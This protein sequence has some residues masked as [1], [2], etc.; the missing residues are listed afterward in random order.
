MW[1]VFTLVLIVYLLY[2]YVFNPAKVVKAPQEPDLF[3]EHEEVI[4]E[5]E[6]NK[7]SDPP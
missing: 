2:K 6:K 3:I 1:K 4:K 7:R 5:H